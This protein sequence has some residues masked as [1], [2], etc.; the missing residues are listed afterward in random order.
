M[1]APDPDR[2]SADG[3]AMTR[4]TRLAWWAA[5]LVTLSTAA[6]V[7][8][9]VASAATTITIRGTAAGRV[10]DGVGAVSG[11]GGN[12]KLLYDYAEPQR[13]QILDYLFRPGYGA[14][15]Q[16]FKTEI[17]GDANSTDG[18]EPSHMHSADDQNYNR[19]YEWWL[20]SAAKARNPGI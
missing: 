2:A 4:R 16:L 1:A 14:S 15:I 17:G 3:A 18:A 10:F 6:V 9:T 11:G 7:P 19:G 8:A 5:V 13:G 20:M 12:S